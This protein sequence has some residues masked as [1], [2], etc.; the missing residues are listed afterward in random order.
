MD[1]IDGEL[2]EQIEKSDEPTIRV[3]VQTYDGCKEEEDK[4]LV[5]SVGGE[6]L[7]D[8]PIISAF[9][10]KLPKTG[11][12]LLALNKRVKKIFYDKPV[13]L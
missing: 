4:K 12:K 8:L 10:A 7:F 3:I 2:I 1:K 11:I 9:V 6:Y 5:K 13:S